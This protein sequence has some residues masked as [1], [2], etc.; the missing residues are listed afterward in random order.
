MMQPV[1]SSNACDFECCYA[2]SDEIKILIASTLV[3]YQSLVQRFS[4]VLLKGDTL[5][6]HLML[7]QATHSQ[8]KRIMVQMINALVQQ[9]VNLPSK[10]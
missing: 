5:L 8:S 7:K 1:L 2:N 9:A 10:Q 4:T 6:V 3:P